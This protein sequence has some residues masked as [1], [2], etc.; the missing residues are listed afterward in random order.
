MIKYAAVW[1]FRG[2]AVGVILY[3]LS[4]LAYI[5]GYNRGYF[6]GYTEGMADIILEKVDPV[7]YMLDLINY[8]GPGRWKKNGSK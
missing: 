8:N 4:T 7:E 6:E 2:A 1:C 3:M 5:K